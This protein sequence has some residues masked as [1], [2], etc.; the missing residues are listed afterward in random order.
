MSI[1][2]RL[3]HEEGLRLRQQTAQDVQ[4][5][6]PDGTGFVKAGKDWKFDRYQEQN[7][8]WKDEVQQDL[9]PRRVGP[10]GKKIPLGTY[11]VYITHGLRNLV[12]ERKGKVKAF[13]FLNRA[14]RNQM[15]VQYQKLEA[16]NRK[17]GDKVVHEWVNDGG[18]QY[19]P[20][21]T[22]YGVFVGDNQRAI[23]DEMPT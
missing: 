20:P 14:I 22:P 18:P 8:A 15:R 16:T 2:L 17:K 1:E 7:G 21:N 19:V 9:D 10:D 6:N 13:N 23:L 5:T 3:T 4:R 11:T 12:V